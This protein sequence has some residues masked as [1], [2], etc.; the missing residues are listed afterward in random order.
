MVRSDGGNGRSQQAVRWSALL[1]IDEQDDN[2]ICNP[3]LQAGH[4]L[5][6]QHA[7]TARIVVYVQAI[8]SLIHSAI[9]HRAVVVMLAIVVMMMTVM[10]VVSVVVVMMPVMNVIFAMCMGMDKE[11]RERAG[12]HRQGHAD[13]GRKS[14]HQRHRPDEGDV[15]SACSFQLRQH[16]FRQLSFSCTRNSAEGAEW[17]L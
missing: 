1:G 4:R 12:W 17:Q 2:P 10:V 14:K 5:G 6:H 15:A 3:V 9:I 16:A 8:L 11:A 13:P 7:G